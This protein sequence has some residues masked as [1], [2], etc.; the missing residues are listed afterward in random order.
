MPGERVSGLPETIGGY[1]YRGGPRSPG[2]ARIMANRAARG[3]R[4]K[5]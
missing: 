3:V 4:E 2:N 1:L 5:R